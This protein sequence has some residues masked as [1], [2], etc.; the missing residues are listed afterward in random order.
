AAFLRRLLAACPQRAPAGAGGARWAATHDR[1]LL[2]R[3]RQ[4]ASRGSLASPVIRG[5]CPRRG[6]RGKAAGEVPADSR[7][8]TLINHLR[9][10]SPPPPPA[11]P[12]PKQGQRHKGDFPLP[13]GS[14]ELRPSPAP[15]P[16]SPPPAVLPFPPAARTPRHSRARP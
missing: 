8:W 12:P 16:R 5:R 7:S 4:C 9:G 2:G 3:R 10:F 13:C 11:T 15:G 1:H 14:D 6:R